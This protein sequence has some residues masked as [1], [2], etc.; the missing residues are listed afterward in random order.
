[1]RTDHWWVD[2]DTI[3]YESPAGS[4]GIPR[5]LVVRIEPSVEREGTARASEDPAG[6]PRAEP[7]RP[8]PAPAMLPIPAGLSAAARAEVRDLMNEG[9]SAF[10]R[11]DFDTA[12]ERFRRAWT[13]EPSLNDAR[14]GFAL[15]EISL[16]RDERAL[17]VVLDG[18][19]RDPSNADLHEILGDLRDREELVDE[20]GR[21]W[22]ESFRLAPNDRR[23]EKILRVERELRAG[24]DYAFSAAP[25]FNLRYDGSVDPDLAS[26]VTEFLESSYRD[27]SDTFRHAPSQ[28]ITVLLYPERQFRDVTQAP[29][30]VGGLYDGKIRVPLG[31]LDR[32]DERARRVLV[33]ELTHAV[34]HSKTRGNCPRWLHEGLAQRAEG[35]TLGR[36][37]QAGIA[38]LLASTD[39]QAWDEG[40]FSYPAALS[41]TL[42]LESLRGAGGL[43]EALDR[44]AEGA[45]PDLALRDV[46]GDSYGDLCRRW[47]VQV[48]GERR[49]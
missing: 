23:R 9:A 45:S 46:F 14:V 42:Y 47:A 20:A 29:D 32:L 10:E 13:A 11:R 19:V 22:R 40:T 1:M 6:E 44:L 21:A 37:D 8:R 15:A 35:R 16:G 49:R 12:S 24:R 41:L 48:L 36:A 5:S 34:V 30:T 33:H 31:G 25:H 7:S 2:G 27:L 26:A 4:V 17:P 18:L 43:V 39:P 38:K 3:F 28:P